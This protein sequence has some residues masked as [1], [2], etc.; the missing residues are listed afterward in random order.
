MLKKSKAKKKTKAAK[1]DKAQD[2]ID[3]EGERSYGQAQGR[4]E[5]ITETYDTMNIE[6]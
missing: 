3:L 2:R 1:P 6:R 5:D 4:P